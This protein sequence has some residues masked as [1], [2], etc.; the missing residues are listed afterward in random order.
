MRKLIAAVLVAGA[1]LIAGPAQAADLPYYPPI[2]ELPPV[3]HGLEGSFYLRGSAAG[4]L[5]WAQDGNNC[6]CIV[7]FNAPGYGYSLGVGV[8]YETGTGLRADVTLDYLSNRG[9]TSTNGYEAR[10][11]SGLLLAN[12]YYDFGFSDYGSA[13]G[14]WG[15]YV[16]AGIGAAYNYSQVFD[17]A[18]AE[19]AWGDTV[20]GAGALMAGVTYDM[21]DVV[22]DI[23]YRAIYMDKVMSTP[24]NL[25]NAYA[26]NKN[27]IHEVRGTVRYRF[28]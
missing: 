9:L 3:D 21:G 22:A 2:I 11:R 13:A 27:W 14:G 15:A 25:A 1:A 12:V 4:N 23:G 19:W 24:P 26:I 5:W 6:A 20:E 18:G 7:E 8:G 17:P 10:L 28:N 16:G